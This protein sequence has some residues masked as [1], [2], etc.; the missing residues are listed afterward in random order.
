MKLQKHKAC[1]PV[2]RS[3]IFLRSIKVD[4]RSRLLI[5]QFMRYFLIHIIFFNRS[6]PVTTLYLDAIL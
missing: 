2:L 4:W 5:R 1:A 3:I 6:I